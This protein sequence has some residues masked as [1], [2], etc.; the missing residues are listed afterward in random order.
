MSTTDPPDR[1]RLAERVRSLT[2][3][4]G[5]LLVAAVLPLFLPLPW[6]LAGLAFAVATMAVGAR[7]LF[8]LAQ[9][10]RLGG[11]GSGF[12]A[13][14]VGLGLA[15]VL[16]VQVG[17]QAA[18]YPLYRDRDACLAQAPTITAQDRCAEEFSSRLQGTV[19]PFGG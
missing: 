17:W 14:S 2:R 10:R 19:A 4:F 8:T 12:V 9:L 7:L 15:A 6:R 16:V 11:R 5:A 3:L 1:E 13:V 18:L